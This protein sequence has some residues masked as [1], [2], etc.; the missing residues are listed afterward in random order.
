MEIIKLFQFKEGNKSIFNK[1][2]F[3][4]IGIFNVKNNINIGMLLRTAAIYGNDFVFTIGERYSYQKADVTRSQLNVPIFNFATFKEAK[5]CMPSNVKM[6]AIEMAKKAVY[7]H[8]YIHPE[9]AV[10]LLGAEDTG[11]PQNILRQCNNIV[12]LPGKISLN[13]GITGSIV[14][15]DRYCKRKE[16]V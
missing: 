8:E 3:S 11:I 7:L 2:G 9:R 16:Y 15:H 10:Y 6:I 14:M 4:G 5:E 13:V 1:E 12:K